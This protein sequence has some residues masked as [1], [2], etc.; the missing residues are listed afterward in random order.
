MKRDFK[1]IYRIL[2]HVE[3]HTNGPIQVP[4]IEGYAPEVVH[5]HV[6]LCDEAG[7]LVAGSVGIYEGK[8][9]FNGIERITWDGHEALDRLRRDNGGTA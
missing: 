1:L 2:C 9:M 4:D 5:Y 3:R 6:G 8:R 7:Y